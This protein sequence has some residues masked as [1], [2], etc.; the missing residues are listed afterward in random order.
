M[1]VALAKTFVLNGVIYLGLLLILDTTFNTPDHTIFG[2]SYS[3][4]TGYPMYLICIVVNARLFSQIAKEA[5]RLSNNPYQTKNESISTATTIGMA[6][7]YINCAAFAN[8][9]RWIPFIGPMLSF[10]VSCIFMAYYCYDYKWM[11]L[12]WPLDQRLS[13]IEHH[14]SYFLGFGCPAT[15]LTFS[16]STLHAGAVFALIYPSYVIMATV[17]TMNLTNL[18]SRQQTQWVLPNQ[19][20]VFWAVGQATHGAIGAIQK[21]G[22]KQMRS[23]FCENKDQLGKIV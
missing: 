3:V 13:H 19:I 18:P 20:P 14:W 21:L 1:Q 2:Y 10:L 8:C 7:F 4:L 22:V 5:F 12:G 23:A 17:A 16:L 9:I 6:I 11:N 15:L